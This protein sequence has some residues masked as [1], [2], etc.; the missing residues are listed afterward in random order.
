MKC[1]PGCHRCLAHP[2][3]SD[4]QLWFSPRVELNGEEWHV[5]LNAVVS[6]GN[7]R[8]YL[9]ACFEVPEGVDIDIL[10]EDVLTLSCILN[11]LEGIADGRVQLHSVKRLTR[12]LKERTSGRRVARVRRVQWRLLPPGKAGAR[13]AIQHYRNLQRLAPERR[14]QEERLQFMGQLDADERYTGEDSFEGYTCFFFAAKAVAVLECPYYGEATY[15]LKGNWQTLSRHTKT[16]LLRDFRE[17]TTR[18]IHTNNFESNFR[19]RLFS[20][21]VRLKDH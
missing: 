11:H 8:E 1:V 7:M 10:A 19:W 5:A 18:V 14:I 20:A 13:Q 17:V 16:D 2:K 4:Y 6:F 12:M 21:G 15:I 3:E 9:D